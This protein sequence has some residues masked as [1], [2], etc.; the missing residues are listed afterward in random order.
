MFFC[1]ITERSARVRAFYL[2]C[3][4]LLLIGAVTMVI[5]FAIMLG[6]SVE[7]GRKVSPSLLPAYLWDDHA[8]WH[9]YIAAKYRNKAD[10]LKMAW[11]DEAVDLLAIGPVPQ[12]TEADTSALSIWEEWRATTRLSQVSFGIGFNDS[13]A[14]VPY[15]H[16]RQFRRW[17]SSHYPTMEAANRALGTTF[18]SFAAIR[19]PNLVLTGGPLGL[20]PF[21]NC[22][23]EFSSTVPDSQKF[24][25]D[26][27]AYYRTVF[28]PTTEGPEIADFNR[29][30]GTTFTRFSEIPFEASHPSVA[31]QA[32]LT[33]VS[34]LLRPDLVELTEHGTGQLAASGL[35][36]TDFI[37]MQAGV[38][39]L[40]V[41][42]PDRQFAQWVQETHQIADAQSPQRA[43]DL[44]AF[45]SEK[46]FW[47]WTFL[48]QNYQYVCDEILLQG[49]AM[50]NTALLVLL[51]VGGTLIVNP[52]AAY[53]LSRFKL[54]QAYAIL[55][56]FLAT[57]SF[58]A[59]VT[60]IPVFLQ[61]KELNLLNTFG[62]LVLPGLANGFS[63]FL[64]KGFFDSLPKELYEAAEIDG[65][66]EWT[67]LWQIAMNLS[68][69]ILAV[70]VLAAFVSAYGAFFY[71]L[72]L[73][74]D[75]KMWT[76]MVYIYQL[77]Q[78]A[79]TPVVYASL[80]LAAIPTLLIFIFCQKIILRGIVVP[81]DK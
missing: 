58:P 11:N 52:L 3:Y 76:I 72:I 42:T 36:R 67:M 12:E 23:L 37:R 78:G 14:S 39:D 79:D 64:L 49:R 24:I 75:P 55:L 6:G 74:P 65:A 81:S 9:R 57:I 51:M 26:A 28:L 7:P 32:W 27:G 19:P 8:L 71:A 5:P 62:A 48:K 22:F 33:F 61:L 43:L 2:A 50:W 47:R 31:P 30:H 70:N 13:V 17:I 56:F 69:P 34:K 4:L 35:A 21:V 15:Y 44:R 29:R 1:P 40:R 10:L 68:K 18:R 38:G 54:R 16:N 41:I 77:Q 59:E 80:I 46:T 60:M 45:E 53:A 73:A 20:T 25:W 66:S 63:I